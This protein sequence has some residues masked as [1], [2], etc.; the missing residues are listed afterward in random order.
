MRRKH[1]LAA[2][3]GGAPGLDPCGRTEV[4]TKARAAVGFHTVGAMPGLLARYQLRAASAAGQI[5]RK[6]IHRM[7]E[8]RKPTESNARGFDEFWTDLRRGGDP[9]HPPTWSGVKVIA[10]ARGYSKFR[11]RIWEIVLGRLPFPRATTGFIELAFPWAYRST[12]TRPFAR[13]AA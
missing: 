3:S 8:G 13:S 5:R 4:M 6:D 12:K 10:E 9:V 11:N 1:T 7:N 2:N